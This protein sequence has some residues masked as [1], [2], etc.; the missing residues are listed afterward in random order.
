M[1]NRYWMEIDPET[2]NPIG[3]ACWSYYDAD[4]PLVGHWILVEEVK[5]EKKGLTPQ[6]KAEKNYQTMLQ[7]QELNRKICE[8]G[9]CIHKEHQK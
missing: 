1:K 9:V 2:K 8:I 7:T 4:R 6:E 3:N 5:E